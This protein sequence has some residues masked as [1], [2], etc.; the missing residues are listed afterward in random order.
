MEVEIVTLK[1]GEPVGAPI[2]LNAKGVQVK[3][4]AE[5]EYGF[6]IKNMSKQEIFFSLFFF[7]M[8][9]FSI[10]QWYILPYYMIV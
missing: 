3:A 9:K 4:D 8:S 6:K 7:D 5:T 1:E 2:R 10:G